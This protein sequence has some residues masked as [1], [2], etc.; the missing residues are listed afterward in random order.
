[1]A[2]YDMDMEK[3]KIWGALLPYKI[4]VGND[5]GITTT[6][7]KYEL[8]AVSNIMLNLWDAEKK[9]SFWSPPKYCQP[10][11][12]SEEMLY[13][14]IT[15]NGETFNPIKKLE[16]LTQLNTEDYELWFDVHHNNLFLLWNKLKKCYV[17]N[18]NHNF[19]REKA[20]EWH[21][22]V[23]GLRENQFIKKELC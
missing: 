14:E 3:L 4:S 13:K 18:D 6:K 16:E 20:L 5:P 12:Y 9:K 8:W 17:V 19:L 1:M 21:I 22:N 15:V 23:L 10:I 7:N 11:L 2:S